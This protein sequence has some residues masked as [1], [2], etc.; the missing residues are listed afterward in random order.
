MDIKVTLTY[1]GEDT[2]STTD[3]FSSEI[4]NADVRDYAQAYAALSNGTLTRIQKG[5]EYYDVEL[6]G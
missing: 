5:G 3:G 6:E 4:A 2:V 1:N